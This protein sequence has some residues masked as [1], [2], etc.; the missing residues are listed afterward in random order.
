MQEKVVSKI[1]AKVRKR[2]NGITLIA[3]V[4]TIVVLLIL[5]G[6]SIVVLF[7]N[8]GI[9][10]TAASSSL[11]TKFAE[12]EEKANIIYADLCAKQY[13]NGNQNKK[14]TMGDV[15]KELENQEYTI[16]QIT[17]G[18]NAVEIIELEKTR[19]QMGTNEKAQIEVKLTRDEKGL[20]YYA[21]V[22]ENYYKMSWENGYIVL[23]KE[24]GK[25][26]NELDGNLENATNKLT[27]TLNNQLITAELKEPNIIEIASKE[28][29][30]T[31]KITVTYGNINPKECEVTIVQKLTKITANDIE[32]KERENKTLE[33]TTEP[34]ENTEK[35]IYSVENI[36]KLMIDEEGNITA[37]D[38]ERG[39]IKD[40]VQV[41]IKGELSGVSTTCTVTIKSYV[42]TYIEYDVS[43]K[44]MFAGEYT[45]L[46]GW[47]L[48]NYTRDSEGYYSNVELISTGRPIKLN[49]QIGEKSDWEISDNDKLNRFRELLR[50]KSIF[51]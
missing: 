50:W 41:T 10:K 19:I 1:K 46:N 29:I 28:N 24:N 9:I 33:I 42:G 12:I 27:I 11:Q 7:G 25:K 47:R 48:L 40:T 20:T 39:R 37:K 15:A 35:I 16:M 26:E 5:A 45:K 6:V 43:Y 49:M 18:E 38:I 34:S 8:N 31:S 51:L 17:V 22:E 14:V 21:K 3:L 30:G 2:Q 23:D 13:I 36:D 44:D 4:V 32:L